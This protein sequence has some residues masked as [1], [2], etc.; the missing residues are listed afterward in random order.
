MSPVPAVSLEGVSKRYGQVDALRSVT[1]EIPSGGA[2][3]Y[4]GPNGA[5][6]STT[7][8]LL[9]GLTKAD[10]GQVRVNGRDPS[11][12]RERALRSVGV[13]VE[14][15]GVLPY[16]RGDD[17]LSHIAEVKGL[18]GSDRSAGIERAA[19]T[20]GAEDS[21]GRTLGSLSTGLLR[22]VLI[23]GALI[24]DPELLVLDEPTLGLDPAARA[25]LRSTLHDLAK[26][27]RTL[28]LSTHL[29]D[30]VSEVCQ[31]VL[32]LREGHIVGDEPV[33]ASPAAGTSKR[34]RVLR[35]TTSADATSTQ[36]GK[37]LQGR[38][39][40][41]SRGPR[42][43]VVRFAG[44]EEVQSDL[45]RALIDAGV[46]VSR[47]ELVGSDLAARYLAKVGREEAT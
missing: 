46:K 38:A 16:M 24:G 35:V 41:E 11:R 27:G 22:R 36:V 34:P 47:A 13:L 31:R 8:K 29:L 6:K 19:R 40:V 32:F 17:L 26:G 45:L 28:F 44:D 25:D 2:V 18:S 14:T 21:L 39:Q 30:D 20:V 9:A 23:A 15:P 37:A 7:L 1:F 42:E 10:A 5:G 12:E 3:G 33:D 4:L 43:L